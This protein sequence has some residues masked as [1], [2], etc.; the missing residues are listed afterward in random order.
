MRT[1]SIRRSVVAFPKGKGRKAPAPAPVRRT[2]NEDKVVTRLA[3]HGQAT[4]S[5]ATPAPTPW[6]KMAWIPLVILLLL[7]LCLQ[8][9]TGLGDKL[10]RDT[11]IGRSTLVAGSTRQDIGPVDRQTGRAPAT[12]ESFLATP[13]GSSPST[14][15]TAPATRTS[16]KPGKGTANCVLKFGSGDGTAKATLNLNACLEDSLVSRRPG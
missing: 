16:A 14:S 10:R 8:L 2:S 15:G 4:V 7:F 6:W 13:Y 12:D 5:A 9:A 1:I 11:E 3:T